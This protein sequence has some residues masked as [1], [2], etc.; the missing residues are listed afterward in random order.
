MIH[1][2]ITKSQFRSRRKQ[3]SR[4]RAHMH[5]VAWGVVCLLLLLSLSGIL[6]RSQ[7]LELQNASLRQ[8]LRALKTAP[9]ST[10]HLAGTWL[11]NS[12][13][14]L[15]V[16]GRSYRVHLPA[17]FDSN[18]YYPLVMLYT[19]KGASPEAVER[20]F[21][22]DALPVVMV[23]PQ[24]TASTDH[25][26]A[27]EGAP[28]SS[29]AD[30]VAFTSTIL[31]QL[32]AKLCID[33]TRIYATGL[34]NG[35]GFASLLSCKLSDKFAAYAVVSGAL[36]APASNCVPPRPV[37]LLNIHGDS[38][39]IVPYNGSLA[40]RLPP[41]DTW[42]ARRAEFNGCKVSFTDNIAP[43]QIATTWNSCRD[44]ATVKSIRVIGGGHAWGLVTNNE[45]W[46]FLSQ[47]TL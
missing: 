35:G 28:Y 23:Y 33:K 3:Q 45:L 24:P 47:F 19:G 40:R 17:A 39:P 30:D 32:Q 14:V 22:M 26:L 11:P 4:Y 10:C 25:S 42:A 2:M 15:S 20:S 31:D 13:T 6:V 16:T 7:S 34:S 9:Q 21:G 29:N 46:Q 12:T 41:I 18:T 8:Q 37:P 38:D 44:N 43:G 27:W 36:Y 5:H 1:T